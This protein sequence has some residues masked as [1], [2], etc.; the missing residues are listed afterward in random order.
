MHKVHTN[1]NLWLR[2][3]KENS[4]NS[5]KYGVSFKGKINNR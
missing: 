3:E 2:N 4:P 1:E 5:I